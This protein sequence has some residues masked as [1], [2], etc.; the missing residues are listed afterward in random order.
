VTE[1]AV[2][3]RDSGEGALKLTAGSVRGGGE[4]E[5]HIQEYGQ[6]IKAYNPISRALLFDPPCLTRS[7]ERAEAGACPRIPERF[8]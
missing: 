1:A 2:T 7:L 4:H 5:E 3:G 8:V 6:E